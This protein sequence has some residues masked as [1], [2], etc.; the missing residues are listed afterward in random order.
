[1]EIKKFIKTE[2]GE[3]F[4][5][6]ELTISEELNGHP[7]VNKEG[8]CI[9]KESIVAS[10]DEVVKL[11]NCFLINR[12]CFDNFLLANSH[13]KSHSKDKTLYGATWNKDGSRII[14]QAKYIG[15]GEWELL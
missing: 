6:E 11:F 14:A 10:S 9:Y 2:S 7:F 5:T 4:D 13:Q 8:W 12:H 1:M 3:I 15:S